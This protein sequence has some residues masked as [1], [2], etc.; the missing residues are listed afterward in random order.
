MSFVEFETLTV[1]HFIH[2]LNY[3]YDSQGTEAATKVA[4]EGLQVFKD[5]KLSDLQYTRVLEAVSKIK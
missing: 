3:V 5:L 4:N 1:D 2:F